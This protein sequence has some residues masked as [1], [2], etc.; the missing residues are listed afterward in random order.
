[1]FF[2]TCALIIVFRN[3]GNILIQNPTHLHSSYTNGDQVSQIKSSSFLSSLLLLVPLFSYKHSGPPAAGLHT[4]L[5]PRWT[6]LSS[7]TAVARGHQ[8]L[9]FVPFIF[10]C[11]PPS[12]AL[13]ASFLRPQNVL[14]SF[15][16]PRS[17]CYIH[18]YQILTL[19]TFRNG[20]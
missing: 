14:I 4:P 7:W 20:V 11:P 16:S 12:I 8:S 15:P 19:K 17:H 13:S 3:L 9:P 2:L 1:M 10:I 18:G 5:P 6:C